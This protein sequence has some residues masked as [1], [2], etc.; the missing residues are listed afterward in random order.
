MQF[1]GYSSLN[2]SYPDLHRYHGF[3]QKMSNLVVNMDFIIRPEGQFTLHSP[4]SYHLHL[5][6]S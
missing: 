5:I 1:F 4:T 3:R 6:G 2:D